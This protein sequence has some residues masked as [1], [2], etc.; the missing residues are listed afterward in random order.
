MVRDVRSTSDRGTSVL[1]N[2]FLRGDG[3]ILQEDRRDHLSPVTSLRTKRP[4]SCVK[5]R[6]D[7]WRGVLAVATVE[8]S[9]GLS[10]VVFG[11]T[12]VARFGG[13]RGRRE[14]VLTVLDLA[15]L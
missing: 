14:P 11:S 8:T 3:F 5:S 12:G 6:R 15:V 7:P 4:P 2:P 10:E 1:L 9:G 13:S